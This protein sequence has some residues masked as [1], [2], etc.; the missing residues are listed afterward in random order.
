MLDIYVN[1]VYVVYLQKPRVVPL[2]ILQEET[3]QHWHSSHCYGVI[4]WLDNKFIT[5]LIEWHGGFLLSEKLWIA[6]KTQVHGENIEQ[7]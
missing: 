3:R 5:R 7:F 6:I 4:A 1:T 2:Q